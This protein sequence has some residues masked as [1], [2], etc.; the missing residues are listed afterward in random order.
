MCVLQ[1]GEAI[2]YED[3]GQAEESRTP[4]ERL[5]PWESMVLSRR[6]VW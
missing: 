5:E 1:V 2:P 3:Q 6:P 4:L